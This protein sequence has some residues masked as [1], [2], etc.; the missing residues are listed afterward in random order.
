MTELQY[1]SIIPTESIMHNNPS[2]KTLY[3]TH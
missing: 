1:I 3:V 2:V